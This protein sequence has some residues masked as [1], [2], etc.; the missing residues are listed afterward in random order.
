MSLLRTEQQYILNVNLQRVYEVYNIAW[1]EILIPR[2]VFYATKGL[3]G[4]DQRKYL[5]KEIEA[6]YKI[7]YKQKDIVVVNFTTN[8][9]VIDK[10]IDPINLSSQLD[11]TVIDYSNWEDKSIVIATKGKEEFGVYTDYDASLEIDSDYDQ[12][13][14]KIIDKLKNI[15]CNQSDRLSEI[16]DIL[17]EDLENVFDIMNIELKDIYQ[18]D[19]NKIQE[20]VSYDVFAKW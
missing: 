8:R 7:M 3:L 18:P 5:A 20:A 4:N 6:G 15:G 17:G 19:I 12:K 16:E 9:S 10:R 2:K 11:T 14:N 1:K 13:F